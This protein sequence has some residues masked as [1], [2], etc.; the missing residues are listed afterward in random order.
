M[1][2]RGAGAADEVDRVVVVVPARDERATVAEAVRAV[3]E[4]AAVVRPRVRVDVVV[5]ADGC[6]DDTAAQARSAGAAVVEI[7]AAN[8][9]AA[10]RVGCRWALRRTD[11]PRRLWIA[12]TDAD[13][14]VPPGWLA[15]HLDASRRSD[16]FL[17]TI[18]LLGADRDRHLAW[19]AEYASLAG[20]GSHEHVHGASLGV[21]ASAY[22]AVG[23]FHELTAHE[24]R[25]LVDRLVATGV[26]PV[27]DGRVPVLTSARHDSRVVEGVG[28]DLAASVAAARSRSACMKSAPS[29]M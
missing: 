8:V 21:R 22:L 26:E 15:A 3:L 18:E 19:A 1:P 9:G 28:P 4:S 17:G 23:G 27:R 6:R 14:L 20:R 24:D 25:D 7:A 12:T 5:V 10:R 13:S 16:A 11:D 29:G 2:D